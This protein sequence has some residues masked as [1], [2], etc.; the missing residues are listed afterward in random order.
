MLHSRNLSEK[1]FAERFAFAVSYKYTKSSKR[2]TNFPQ[3]FS[4]R[5]AL[6]LFR[7][8]FFIQRKLS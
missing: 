5:S 8:A 2:G 7:V 4:F 6:N 3:D 1:T